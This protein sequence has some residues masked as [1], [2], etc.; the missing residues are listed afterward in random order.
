[1]KIHTALFA[2]FA[3][4]S[5]DGLLHLD[6]A[7]WEHVTVGSPALV[8]TWVGGLV[9]FRESEYDSPIPMR[10]EVVDQWG[11]NLGALIETVI[12]SGRRFQPFA[13][14]VAFSPH[15]GS[16]AFRVEFWTNGEVCGRSPE[17]EV[18][19]PQIDNA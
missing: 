2:N 12:V 1:M 3:A 6:G 15:P 4:V 16:T 8:K 14:P 5:P 17:C 18:R 19:R 10:I 9:E 7:G 13:L 11:H